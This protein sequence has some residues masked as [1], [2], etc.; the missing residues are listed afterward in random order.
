MNMV[1]RKW[2]RATLRRIERA[3]DACVG[4]DW[5]AQDMVIVP[6]AALPEEF[7]PGVAKGGSEYR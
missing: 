3:R 1:P 7:L 5:K 6:V 2:P 4:M